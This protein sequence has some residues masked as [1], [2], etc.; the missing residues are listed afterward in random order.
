MKKLT[1][2]LI[3]IVLIIVAALASTAVSP[4]LIIAE[5]A[6]E[7]TPG[8]DMAASFSML[9]GF[10]W[11]YPG[12]SY[13]ANG[14]TLHNIHMIDPDNPYGAAKDIM[15]YTYHYSPHVIIGVNN[16]AAEAIFGS[17]IIDNTRAND[18]YNGYAGS[19][20]V[21]GTM[22]RGDALGTAMSNANINILQIPIQTLMGNIQFH[23]V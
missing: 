13:N 11:V 2:V 10:E 9:G 14:E 19:G 7:G 21:Q 15:E 1:A 17:D 4:V 16:D 8:V 22:S 5:D 18:A 3:V 6:E 12:S 20:N 23:F